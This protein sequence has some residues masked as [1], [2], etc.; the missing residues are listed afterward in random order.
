MTQPG[1]PAAINGFLYQILHHLDWLA[2]FGLNGVLDGEDVKDGCLVLE[3][4]DGG[5]A[6]ALGS[7]LY[8]VEQYK[9]RAGGTWSLSDV[10]EVL[11]DLRK[12]VPNW[13]PRYGH[14]RF[15]TD[16]R[17]GELR[18]F[19]SFLARLKGIEST[20]DLDN[21]T[22][23]NF[24]RR[25]TL[26][27]GDRDFLDHVALKTRTRV[28]GSVTTV[29]RELIFHLLYRFDMDFH[30]NQ[31]EVARSV[32]AQ[33]RPY[34]RNLGDEIGVRKRLIG[35]LME[36]LS[37]REVRFNR[38]H[39]RELLQSAGLSPDR[40]QKVRKLARK[41]EGGMRRRSAYLRYRRE[42]DVREVPCWPETKH[43]L[44][45]MGKSGAGKS[46]QLARLMEEGAKAGELFVFIRGDG[47]AEE[48]LTSAARELW[49]V[50]LGETSDLTLQAVSNFFREESFQL[51]SPLFTVVV[52]DVQRNDV[53]RRLVQQDWSSLGA[54]LALTMPLTLARTFGSTDSEEISFHHVG[55]F[56]IDE[57]DILLKKSGQRWADLPGDLKRLLRNPILAGLYLNL[58]VSSFYVAP[59]S[60][61]EIF[62][63]FWDRIDEK[64][65]RGDKGI[66]IAL[67]DL[68]LQC[69]SS[70]RLDRTQWEKIGLTRESLA[71]LESVGWLTCLE[72]GEVEFTHD[73]LLNWAAAQFLSR[74]FMEQGLSLETLVGF[75]TGDAVASQ[76]LQGKESQPGNAENKRFSIAF[77]DRFGYVQMDT[78]WSLSKRGANPEVL[79]LIVENMEHNCAFEGDSHYHYLYTYLLPTLGEG[80]IPILLRR[81]DTIAANFPDNYRVDLIGEAFATLA[82]RGTA[83]IQ[84]T[85]DLLVQS[86]SWDW[87]SVAVRVLAAVLDSKYMDRL[88]EIHHQRL[89]ARDHGAKHR[90]QQGHGVTFSALRIG[91]SRHPEWL[92]DRISKADPSRERVSELAYLLNGLDHPEAGNI[93]QE[94]RNVL[95]AKVMQSNNSRSLRSLLYG[96]A[97]FADHEM[98]N[99]VIKY[100]S[101]SDEIV[102]AAAWVALVALDPKEAINRIIDINDAQ[103]F[104]R[105]EW[106]PLCLRADS[107]QTR[108]RLRELA[109]S[110]SRGQQLIQSY[111]GKHPADL[112]R[113]TLD[114][115]LQTSENKFLD[116]M[117]E[118]TTTD[119]LW[120]FFPLTSLGQMCSPQLLRILHDKAESE[121]ER[122]IV[123][124]ACSKVREPLNHQILE[125]A[126]RV[127]IL[128]AGEG[129]SSLINDELN[130]E[131]FSVRLGGLKWAWI[132]GNETTIERLSAI[133]RRPVLRSCTGEPDPKAFREHC[134]AMIGLAAQGA[135]KILVEILSNPGVIDVRLCLADFRKHQGPM[136]KSL[137][138]QA[139]RAMRSQ[140]TS[141]QALWC[142]LVIA[143]LSD[144][145]ELIQDVR[146][147]LDHAEP[148]SRNALYACAALQ[149]LG[150]RT[151]DFAR[152]AERLA[153]TEKNSKDG[154]NALIELGGE[155]VEGLKRWLE[156]KGKTEPINY[157]A[158][159][160]QSLYKSAKSRNVAI[161]AAVE[162][163]LKHRDLLHAL[164]EIAAESD[165]ETIRDLIVEDAFTK[166]SANVALN[167]MRGLVKFDMRRAV[168]AIKFGLSNHPN[169]ERELCQLL[170]QV[171]PESALEMLVDAAM[172]LERDTLYDA[173]GRALRRVDPTNVSNVV[174]KR[175][176]GT[177]TERRI[178][179]RIAE[180][181]P[182]SEIAEVLENLADL[183]SAI[184]V[185]RAALH[186]LYKH[187]E[188]EALRGLFSKFQ[189]ERCAARRWSIFVAILDSADPYLLTECEDELWLGHILTNDVPFA[190][191]HYACDVIGRRKQ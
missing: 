121:L 83:D 178:F 106:L 1:G 80:A 36:C 81:L 63:A 38:D 160:I 12:S 125:A 162:L 191:E 190:F 141:E 113:Q 44:A 111:F 181:L 120:P 98:K 122:I 156:I 41:L 155:G 164:Y 128:I 14:Y 140:E 90:L 74:K 32:E 130:S 58:S 78:L 166:N 45:V 143:W 136:P 188:Q 27:L 101:Y 172:S 13:Q 152:L 64:C 55:E 94:L 5:D 189:N 60:E 84:S 91:V 28:T 170:V 51:R 146:N 138:A 157:C 153:F 129:I 6:Q 18:S 22:K 89:E 154:M 85:I 133:A 50:G 20:D 92:C 180:W 65:L 100:L 70:Y 104:S 139:V 127:L 30:I 86:Q 161:E 115:I 23:H 49:Q 2:E 112:D 148:E 10:M 7:D 39:I 8:L 75:M 33:L 175:L 46:W 3:P 147:V 182:I 73:R 118:I 69:N 109:A 132:H 176:R 123:E 99:F 95:M 97:R 61:Y 150:D 82:R 184:A 186:A 57:L 116:H 135:D 168:E 165:H 134:D 9:T 144:D 21:E 102:S 52:D 11:R 114:F 119:Q 17:P 26:C 149:R 53:A 77:P 142:S 56:S 47:T 16:G 4:R 105:N 31:E 110:N 171:V 15:V 169:I 68:A 66:I 158:I 107:E 59:Q 103:T 29:E 87:Q 88:W 126:R 48:I 179:C 177:E 71:A 163:C 131:H 43:V 35:D 185:R 76:P 79:D 173:I 62:Q 187:R 96:I 124:L 24:A 54:R 183:D 167:G 42:S 25:Q 117:E 37:A 34:C 174:L 93:W 108:A 19:E 67:A 40:L 151:A 159:V 72:H 137:T 145:P